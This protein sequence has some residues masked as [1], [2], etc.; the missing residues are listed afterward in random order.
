VPVVEE[1]AF[2]APVPAIPHGVPTVTDGIDGLGARMPGSGLKPPIPSSVDPSGMPTRP[3]P[4]EKAIPV[5][6]EA[7]AAG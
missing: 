3:M 6:D 7:D 5:G 4:D 2:I 1:F